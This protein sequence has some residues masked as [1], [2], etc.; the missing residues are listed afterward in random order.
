MDG[1]AATVAQFQMAGNEVGVKVAEKDVADL[2]AK[3]LGVGQV[4]LDIALR[5]DDD[6]GGTGLVSHQI[7]RV[8]QTAEVV[9]LQDHESSSRWPQHGRNPLAWRR[10][11]ALLVVLR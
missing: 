2:E 1:R 11:R 4:L 5:I 3:F 8:R 7:R 10:H 9:L 6:G